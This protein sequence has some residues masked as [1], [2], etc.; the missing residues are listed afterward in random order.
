M[1]VISVIAEHSKG[2][3]I[4]AVSTLENGHI[5]VN[6]QENWFY[7]HL[8]CAIIIYVIKGPCVLTN[9]CI[10]FS[11]TSMLRQLPRNPSYLVMKL[12]FFSEMG[13]IS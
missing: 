5:T 13:A 8:A 10:D 7:L 12:T 4:S 1:S 2:A 6:T 11:K 9:S 3:M